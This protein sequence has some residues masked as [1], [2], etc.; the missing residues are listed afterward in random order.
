M[1]FED[2]THEDFAKM[3]RKIPSKHTFADMAKFEK[4][5]G[6]DYNLTYIESSTAYFIA[7]ECKSEY[8]HISD[9]VKRRT[10]QLSDYRN[11]HP[12]YKL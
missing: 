9:V 5:I 4:E 2:L 12:R 7:T 10:V 8:K 6:D 11:N 1:K 3:S